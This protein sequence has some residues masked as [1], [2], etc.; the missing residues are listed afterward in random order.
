MEIAKPK[1]WI[2]ECAP[3]TSTIRTSEPHIILNAR[4][5]EVPQE[6][7]RAFHSNIPL[8][9]NKSE[10][11]VSVNEA[12]EWSETK[13]LFNHRSLNEAAYSP[14]YLSNRPART[15][16]TWPIRIYKEG[17]MTIE[18]MKIIQGFPKS[19]IFSG[20]KTEQYKQIGNAVAPPVGRAIAEYLK[21]IV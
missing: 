6:R 17:I 21:S 10:R 1:V 3:A 13:V 15:A 14:V 11:T 8:L 9:P 2:W 7:K 19:Y 20:N 5:F 16:V 18:Q 12:L 4:D